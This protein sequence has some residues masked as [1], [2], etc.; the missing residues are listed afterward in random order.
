MG[1]ALSE[2]YQY[3]MPELPGCPKPLILRTGVEII[4]EWCVRTQ[5]WEQ[6]LNDI[7]IIDG[8]KDYELDSPVEDTEVIACVSRPSDGVG[9]KNDGRLLSPGTEYTIGIDKDVITLYSEPTADDD[10]ALK[11]PV[12]LSIIL[13]STATTEVPERLFSDNHGIWA[14]GTMSRLML[15]KKKSWT[16][17]DTGR[18]YHNIYW[19][20]IRLAIA[21]RTRGRTNRSLRVQH[22]TDFA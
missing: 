7:D 6:D 19:D 9:V 11:I 10:E 2:M 21:E 14:Y 12:A 18:L 15:Q 8:Q 5:A 13:A 1:T 3:V 20:G 17:S 16:D 4:R 22:P